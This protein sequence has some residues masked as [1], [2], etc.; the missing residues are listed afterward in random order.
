V[1]RA[2]AVIR[3]DWKFARCAAHYAAI[4]PDHALN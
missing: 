3:R 4:A 1:R 2:W